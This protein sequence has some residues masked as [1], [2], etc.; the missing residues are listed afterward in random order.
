MKTTAEIKLEFNQEIKNVDSQEKAGEIRVKYFG[1]KGYISQLMGQMREAEDKKAFGQMVNDLKQELMAEFNQVEAKIQE[2]LLEEKLKKAAIDV[3]ID[4]RMPKMGTQNILIQTARE[5]EAIFKDLGFE[6]AI[7]QE[8]E[9]DYH[10][11]EA[12]NLGKDH[13]ARDM[14]DTFYLDP[15]T[16]L[17]THTSNIQSRV[18]SSN[19]NKELK[20]ICPGKVFRRDDDDATHSHQFMQTEG[21]VVVR[22][23]AGRNASLKDLK[24]VLTIFVNRIFNRADLEVRFRPSFFPFTEPSVEVDVTCSSCGGSGC[25]FCKKTGWIEVLGAGII[26]KNVLS[27]A[28]YDADEFTG[29]AFGIGVERIAL[30]KHNIEDIRNLYQNDLRFIRQFD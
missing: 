12:L 14:Q 29:F 21:L 30:L 10:N 8:V 16:L 20:I 19:E 22:K 24:T 1:K 7:G 5:I 23:E 15:V 13:P 9:S 28:G 2:Q 18:L 4:G 27:L 3:T 17:R 11:F 26:H 6:I 25:S